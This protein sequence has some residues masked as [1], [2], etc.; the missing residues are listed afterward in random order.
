MASNNALTLKGSNPNAYG[1][2]NYTNPNIGVKS[3]YGSSGTA[4]YAQPQNNKTALQPGQ[5]GGATQPKTSGMIQPSPSTPLKKVTTNNVDGSSVTHEYYDNK[6]GLLTP[7]GK[8]AG[9]PEVN[10]PKT[11]STAIPAPQPQIPTYSGL[12]T[13][14]ANQQN[15]P[16]NQSN[17][18]SI[19]LLQGLSKDNPATS[20]PAFDA[21]TEAVKAQQKLQSDIAQQYGKIEGDAIPLEFQQGREQALA[22]QYASQLAAAQGAVQQQQ[23]AIGQQIQGL[24][25]QQSGLVNA[26]NLAN[27]GQSTLQSGLTS[28]GTLAQPQLG[29]YGQTYYNPLTQGQGGSSVQLSGVPANDIS[30]FSNAV[31]NGQMD[32][33]TALSQLSG[34]GTAI[35]NQ[36]LPAIQKLQPNFNVAQSQTLAAQQGSIGPAYEYAKTALANLQN[37][38]GGLNAT[39]NTNIPIIN[40]IT[41]GISTTFGVGSQAVQAYKGALAEARSAIQKVLASTQGGT[42]TDYVGQSNALL[43]DNAT[44]NQVNAA[45][46]TLKTLGEA[47]INIYGNPGASNSGSTNTGGGLV[48]TTIGPVNTNW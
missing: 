26:G 3:L 29:Q 34:Y 8:A 23:A 37:A 31:A 44:P 4:D 20:G 40:Q 28:A 36:L 11:I 7:E 24:G 22:R 35:Q 48:Q 45:A 9:K 33:N 6:T 30:T 27:T 41:Q 2:V 13:N 46:E 25:Q 12:I 21:Y 19:G 10:A 5:F 1:G 14:L 38:V 39:Q 42:P 16:Y 18:Q 32:Y 47:K 15:S 43:P 17:Q